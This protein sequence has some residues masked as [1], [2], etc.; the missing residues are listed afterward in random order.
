MGEWM[1]GGRGDTVLEVGGGDAVLGV[2]EWMNGWV[3]GGGG[4]S[5]S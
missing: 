1:G 2:G 4:Y 5:D 3:W